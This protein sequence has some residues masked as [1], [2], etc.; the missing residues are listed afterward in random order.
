MKTYLIT[1]ATSGIGE[2]CARRCFEQGDRVVALCRNLEKAQQLFGPELSSGQLVVFEHDLAHN[3]GL[4]AQCLKELK[5]FGI[6]RMIHCAGFS[7]IQRLTSA[8]HEQQ[9]K[10][11]ETH[12]LALTE[13]ARAL[14]RLRRGELSMLAL[15]STS[16]AIYYLAAPIY[17]MAKNNIE[18]YVRLLNKQINAQPKRLPPPEA[19]LRAAEAITDPERKAQALTVAQAQ[20]GLMVRINAL[21]PCFVNTPMVQSDFLVEQGL[22]MSLIPMDVVVDTIM[23]ILES[24]YMSGQVVTLNNQV[25]C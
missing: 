23:W 8:T 7:L 6:D 2:A 16:A 22:A 13:I 19:A 18:Y 9:L 15:S 11:Y 21:A 12:V 25:T 14:L 1:G 20:A 5:P 10:M 3:E 24:Q 4:Y 17:S